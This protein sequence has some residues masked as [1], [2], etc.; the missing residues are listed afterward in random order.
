VAAWSQKNSQGSL[1]KGFDTLVGL[2]AWF[3]WNER[4]RRVFNSAMSQ[5]AELASW[6]REEVL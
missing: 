3:I 1:W 5:A 2:V 6:I 4:N